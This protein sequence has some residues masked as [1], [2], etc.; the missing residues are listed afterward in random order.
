MTLSGSAPAPKFSVVFANL[1]DDTAARTLETL[2][3]QKN[4]DTDLI[5]LTHKETLPALSQYLPSVTDIW[6]LPMS[7]AECAFRLQKWQQNYKARMDA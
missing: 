4:T 1:Q 3:S 2:I 5:V 7:E 6:T